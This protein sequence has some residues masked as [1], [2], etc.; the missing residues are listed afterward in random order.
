[1]AP[2]FYTYRGQAV[3]EVLIQ[4]RITLRERIAR[5]EFQ[6]RVLFEIELPEARAELTK[7]S[8]ELEEVKDG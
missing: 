8:E 4:R 2:F 6:V 3:K 7:V 5:I 1:M